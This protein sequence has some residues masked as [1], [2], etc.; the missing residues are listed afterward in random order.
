M[1]TADHESSGGDRSGE[2]KTAN[3]VGGSRSKLDYY[4]DLLENAP[5][6]YQSLDANGRIREVN[7]YWCS[8][9]GY[10]RFEA[11]GRAFAEFIPSPF[12]QTFRSSFRR[13]KSQGSISDRE[14]DLVARDGKVLTVS[15]DGKV[16]YDGYGNF[17]RTHCIMRDLTDQRRAEAESRDNSVKL[18]SFIECSDSILILHDLDGNY[19]YYNGPSAF[20]VDQKSIVGKSVSDLFSNEEARRLLDQIREVASSRRAIQVENAVD[21][22]GERLWFLDHVYPVIDGDGEVRRVGKVCLNITAL[23]EK[24][25]LLEEAN[26]RL[27][28]TIDGVRRSFLLLDSDYRVIMANGVAR[29]TTRKIL[30]REIGAGEAILDFVPSSDRED[31]ESHLRSA[32]KGKS[33]TVD[34]M[35]INDYDEKSWYRYSFHPVESGKDGTSSVC[36]MV[37]DV[38]DE[39]HYLSEASRLDKLESVG[40]LAAGIAHEFNNVLSGIMGSLSLLKAD[41]DIHSDAYAIAMEAEKS[42]ARARRLTEQLITFSRGGHLVKSACLVADIVDEALEYAS[43]DSGINVKQDIAGDM[44]PVEADSSQF[45]ETLLNLLLNA[46]Q[47]MPVG[48]YV[49]I[50]GRNIELDSSSGIPLDSGKYVS[51]AVSDSGVGIAAD[52]IDRI[53]DPFYSTKKVGHG[54]GLTASYAIAR[55]HGGHITVE[56]TPYLGSKFT[57]YIPASSQRAEDTTTSQHLEAKS[58]CRV[59][60][61]DSEPAVRRFA[62][63]TLSSL[64]YDVTNAS[65]ALEGMS[66]LETAVRSGVGYDLVI[67]DID[68]PECALATETLRKFRNLDLEIPVLATCHDPHARLLCEFDQFGF[69]GALAKPYSL[70][71]L[72][73]AVSRTIAASSR[74]K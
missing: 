16:Q 37:E 8:L 71:Q 6:A 46:E 42:A 32:Y 51:I 17:L 67:L 27:R 25:L 36:L 28:T 52:K 29:D 10:D 12:L 64:G 59:L 1:D 14:F 57:V 74:G 34:R 62:R 53:F 22:N 48:G 23:K 43:L 54:L 5:I 9:L 13:F 47:A 40:G 72:G 63:L 68:D 73:S 49:T 31:F 4:A 44:W 26:A 66:M 21:W 45:V 20:G 39:H 3:P 18:S 55:R 33:V 56:S 61:I 35:R 19:L 7:D 60:F 41:L 58:S 69:S 30:G 38:T 70:Y 11:I 65:D 24:D 15:F 2:R 50:T